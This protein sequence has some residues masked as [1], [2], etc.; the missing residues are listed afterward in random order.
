MSTPVAPKMSDTVNELTFKLFL[1]VQQVESAIRMEPEVFATTKDQDGLVMSEIE[2][3][4]AHAI[5]HLDNIVLHINQLK[6][7]L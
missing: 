4:L 5:E 1:E 6:A 3:M 7:N 2:P